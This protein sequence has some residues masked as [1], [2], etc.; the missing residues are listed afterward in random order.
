VKKILLSLVV[1]AG[2]AHAAATPAKAEITEVEIIFINADTNGDLVIGKAEFIIVATTQFD[3]TDS[4]RNNSL[5]KKEVGALA[6]DPE[7]S[8]NDSDK[9]G[10]LSFEEMI[11]E[12]LADFASADT[13]GDGLLSFEEVV[14][15]YEGA[16]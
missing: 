9:D 4:D 12:K 7:F 1:L 14:K 13:N 2:L 11:Q 16:Q 15:A 3:L 6:D 8:D 5:D 10:A